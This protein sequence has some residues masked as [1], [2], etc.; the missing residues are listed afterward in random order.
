M[1]KTWLFVSLIALFVLSACSVP[2]QSADI[3]G[4]NAVQPPV[5]TVVQ[6]VPPSESRT[7]TVTGRGQVTL[8]PD[9][10]YVNIGVHSESPDVG[11]ALNE[12]NQKSQDVA[13]VIQEL[14]VSPQDIQTSSFNIYP[15]QQWDPQTGQS[16]GTTFS[17]DN[18]VNVTVRDLQI[19]GQLLDVVVQSG[20]NSI[21]GISFDVE[22]KSEAQSQA[23]QLAVDS[24]RSQ[25]QELAQAAG[26]S[27]GELQSITVN[28]QGYMGPVYEGR[29]GMAQDVAQVPIAAGQILITV[30]VSASFIIE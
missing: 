19:I 5:Q 4:Q 3:S 1:K 23:R 17:V 28:P 12:N 13:S 22:D 27:L 7:I 16:T 9:L 2:V 10:A 8:T 15:Q 26:V 25:A 29:G 24:A 18:T 20:A 21:N 6:Q 14:G 11:E 30:D